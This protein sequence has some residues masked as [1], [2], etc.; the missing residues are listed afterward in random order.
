MK[1]IVISYIFLPQYFL[2]FREHYLW[3]HIK[4]LKFYFFNVNVIYLFQVFKQRILKNLYFLV[5]GT[6][7]GKNILAFAILCCAR[8]PRKI[9]K[10]R[11]G[12]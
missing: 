12:D 10:Q 11:E 6:F 8:M 5:P 9:P 1:I 7:F 4:C 2:I 3:L